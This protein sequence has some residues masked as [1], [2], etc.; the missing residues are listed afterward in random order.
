[1]RIRLA[2]CTLLTAGLA[3]IGAGGAGAETTGIYLCYSQSQVTP[4]VWDSATA[5]GLVAAGYWEPYAVSGNVAGDTNIGGYHLV[6]TLPTGTTTSGV[7]VDAD[8]NAWPVSVTI[9]TSLLG[10]YPVAGA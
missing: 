3:A 10:I 2:L 1:M 9:P 4:G 6:C 5:A 8:G 7:Y